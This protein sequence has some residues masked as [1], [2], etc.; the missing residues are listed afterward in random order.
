VLEGVRHTR[1][2]DGHARIAVESD[3]NIARG[4][5]G[6]STARI[7]SWRGRRL[8]TRR[9]EKSEGKAHDH[10]ASLSSSSCG[11]PNT[12]FS[13]EAPSRSAGL[14]RCNSM[15]DGSEDMPPW[16]A[17]TAHSLLNVAPHPV[18]FGEAPLG[19]KNVNLW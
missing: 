3:I 8:P 12:E 13:G 18:I 14:V 7:F 17:P 16:V 11:P 19:T 2:G 10:Q 15:F 5:A 4:P 1:E 9:E 6:N